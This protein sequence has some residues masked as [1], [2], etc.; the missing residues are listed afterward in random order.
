MVGHNVL[1][2]AAGRVPVQVVNKDAIPAWEQRFAV[3]IT[4]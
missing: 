3:P 4:T 2:L 1:E